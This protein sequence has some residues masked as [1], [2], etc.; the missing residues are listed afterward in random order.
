MEM[1][2]ISRYCIYTM[3]HTDQLKHAHGQGGGA[4]TFE[5]NKRWVEGER[6]FR[7]AEKNGEQMPIL[8]TAAEK[9]SGLLCYAILTDLHL[10][11]D[12]HRTRYSFTGLTPFYE[13]RPKSSLIKKSDNKPLSDNYI[14]PYAICFTPDL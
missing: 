1:R 6:L 3:R 8:F 5:E 11:P 9:D 14:R 10:D 7:E 4:G 2:N 13:D 12:T